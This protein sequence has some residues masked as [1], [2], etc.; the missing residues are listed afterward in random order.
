MNR[1]AEA[2]YFASQLAN[3]DG[4][5]CQSINLLLAREFINTLMLT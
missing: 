5:A 2:E 3:S 4:F 1:P